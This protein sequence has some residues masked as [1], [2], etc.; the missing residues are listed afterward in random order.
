VEESNTREGSRW[1]AHEVLRWLHLTSL[2][3]QAVF[4]VITANADMDFETRQ[5]FAWVHMGLG[6]TTFSL[7]AADGALVFF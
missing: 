1:R 5:S 6:V 2:G 3:L 4:G 7:F